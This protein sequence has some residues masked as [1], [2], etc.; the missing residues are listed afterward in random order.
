[1][2]IGQED[3]IHAFPLSSFQSPQHLYK[4]AILFSPN[5]LHNYVISFPP[6]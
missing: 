3:N 5:P 4:H 1:F 2:E 6:N